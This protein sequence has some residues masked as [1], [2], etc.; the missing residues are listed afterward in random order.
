M[1]EFFSGARMRQFEAGSVQEISRQGERI[2]IIVLALTRAGFDLGRRAIEFVA[3]N[4][5]SQ[6]RHVNADLVSSTGVDFDFEQSELAE[7]RIELAQNV[8]VRDGLALAGSLCRHSYAADGVAADAG[9]DGPALFLGP[10]VHQRDIGFLH[11]T[12]RE[13]RGEFAVSVVIF[14]DHDQATGFFVETVDNAGAH[15]SAQR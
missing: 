3:D 5:M 7:R 14:R 1:R 2:G 9:V 10:A 6:R 12:F 8:V 11:F 4:G 13:L 15:L